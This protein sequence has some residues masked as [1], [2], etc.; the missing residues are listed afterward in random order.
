MIAATAKDI[1]FH[2]QHHA[3]NIFEGPCDWKLPLQCLVL[4]VQEILFQDKRNHITGL[5]MSDGIVYVIA[6]IDGE[7]GLQKMCL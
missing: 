6:C 2:A 4:F 5:H 3:Y 1:N 7:N